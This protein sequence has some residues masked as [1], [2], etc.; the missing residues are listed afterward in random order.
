MRRGNSPRVAVLALPQWKLFPLILCSNPASLSHWGLQSNRVFSCT[1][2]PSSG[3]P[4]GD[5]DS[6]Y[7]SGHVVRNP[8]RSDRVCKFGFLGSRNGVL[9]LCWGFYVPHRYSSCRNVSCSDI[10]VKDEA[11][12]DISFAGQ[13]A[14]SWPS[15]WPTNLCCPE[16]QRSSRWTWSC[17]CWGHPTRTSGRWDSGP[18]GRTLQRWTL[19]KSASN[20]SAADSFC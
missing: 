18:G 4:P 2:V 6:N 1:Q 3:A 12:R 9:M 8:S 17:S 15:C 20:T 14:V 7:S 16:P 11:G 13:W 5:K 19:Q 10:T